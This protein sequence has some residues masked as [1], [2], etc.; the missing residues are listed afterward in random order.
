MSEEKK[1]WDAWKDG[2]NYIVRAVMR[3][4]AEREQL[5][6]SDEN[7]W[8]G[9]YEMHFRGEFVGVIAHGN[10]AELKLHETAHPHITVLDKDR[11]LVT[12]ITLG[13]LMKEAE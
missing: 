9:V 3:Q 11:G 2:E 12:I 10:I 13:G 6:I 8:P 1:N 5:Q 4:E 7:L